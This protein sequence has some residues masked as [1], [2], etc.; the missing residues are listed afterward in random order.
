MS[1][2]H[3]CIVHVLELPLSPCQ[4]LILQGILKHADYTTGGGAYPS[5]ATLARYSG[6]C[7]RKV[8]QELQALC[9]G[10]W[11][12]PQAPATRR[13]ATTY[14]AHLDRILAAV[15]GAQPETGRG[16]SEN[17]GGVHPVRTILDP[18]TSDPEI[19]DRVH[20]MHPTWT[21]VLEALRVPRWQLAK[22][23]KL[24][25]CDAII[26]QQFR[27]KADSDVA[28]FLQRHYSAELMTALAQAA[29]GYTV[30]W[31]NGPVV[32]QHP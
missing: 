1:L 5:I 15:R 19:Q 28:G 24:T 8:Q 23:W 6:F 11:I 9:R 27:V 21:G 16:A 10:R 30:E 29:P 4:K 25:V 31:V 2:T 18:C 7:V 3:D 32:H 17:T 22:F 14:Q 20:P 13:R 12:S 26:N